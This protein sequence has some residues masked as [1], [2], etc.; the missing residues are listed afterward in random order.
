M[1]SGKM[2]ILHI[3]VILAAGCAFSEEIL[4]CGE[5]E[6]CLCTDLNRLVF[7]DG[8]AIDM[9]P[10]F[11]VQRLRCLSLVIRNT[12]ITTLHRLDIEG[13]LVL[14]ELRI[15]GNTELDCKME[16]MKISALCTHR[17]ITLYMPC[18]TQ[19]TTAQQPVST[20]ARPLHSTEY[21]TTHS[22]TQTQ[23]TAV[24]RHNH[25]TGAA[26]ART[27]KYDLA[28]KVGIPLAIFSLTTSIAVAVLIFKR[29]RKV[30]PRKVERIYNCV[31]PATEMSTI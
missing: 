16:K 12:L 30:R 17:N 29:L 15:E 31:F 18:S 9:F 24:P 23:S 27:E 28:I 13:W 26:T 19:I 20:T 10:V 8:P 21:G 2:G 4:N 1:R 25:T 6:H 22:S 7:C 3:L 5:P 14:R 11:H